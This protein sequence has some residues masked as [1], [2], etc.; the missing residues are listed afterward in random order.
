MNRASSGSIADWEAAA[1]QGEDVDVILRSMAR[2]I[3]RL[4]V[5]A[6]NRAS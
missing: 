3:F 6:M 5:W 1:R 4:K 2:R